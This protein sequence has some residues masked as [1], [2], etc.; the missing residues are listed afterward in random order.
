VN[1]PFS[2]ARGSKPRPALVV[3]RTDFNQSQGDVLA[4]PITSR[5]EE[6]EY[7][8]II[9]TENLTEGS[10]HTICRVR[11]DKLGSIDK[12]LMVYRIGRVKKE[13]FEKVR[14]QIL[15]LIN[16]DGS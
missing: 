14:A 13:T 5:I 6:I 15:E 1:Y 16:D 4:C 7:S 9:S 12:S 8:L 10:L 2:N 3:S 11:F